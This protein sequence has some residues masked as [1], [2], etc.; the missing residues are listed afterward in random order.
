VDVVN[1]GFALRLE[2]FESI[3]LTIKG[4]LESSTIFKASSFFNLTPF[5]II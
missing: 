1:A 5:F 2:D 4:F 3:L